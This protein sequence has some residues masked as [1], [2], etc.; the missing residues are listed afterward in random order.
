[1]VLTLMSSV[2]AAQDAKTVIDNA[3]RAMGADRVK[4]L[5]YSGSGADFGLGQGQ[6][7]GPYPRFLNKTHTRVI[8][9]ETPATHMTRVRLQG[10]NPP[11]GGQ[12][13]PMRGE[14]TQNQ[15]V[16]VNP[17]TPWGNQLPI[18]MDPIGFLRAAAARNA[19]VQTQTREGRTYQVVSFTAPNKAMFNGYI[20][21]QNLVERVETWID[22]AMFGDMLVEV[23]YALYRDFDG[24]KYP[25]SIV[26]KRG[27]W[28]TLQLTLADVKFNVAANIK[29]PEGGGGGAQGIPQTTEKLAEGIYL[30]N[31]DRAVLVFDFRDYI[32]V[33]EGPTSEARGLYII[34]EAKRLIPNKPIRYV[35]NTHTHFDHASGL[36]PFVAEG[37]TVITH[38][39]NRAFLERVFTA[40]R[41]LNPDTLSRSGRKPRFETMTTRKVLTDGN[42]V[43]ELHQ[44]QGS[45]HHPGIIFAYLPKQKILFE[46]DGYNANVPANSP[47]PNPVGPYTVNLVENVRRLNL[48]IDRIISIHPPPD[49]RVVTMQEMLRAAGM[50]QD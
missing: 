18:W 29:A 31:G 44:Q 39:A 47:T 7:P 35:V 36:R 41:T 50:E 14:T 24:I 46:G 1:M 37:A 15:T 19:T 10:E 28:P 38:E 49:N 43:I 40:P 32:V 23:D 25:T 11:R 21:A 33:L 5:E 17:K 16:V 26:E 27:G 3:S 2:A 30:L 6:N 42:H 4:T 9:F 45:N 34:E 13:Q 48:D 20:N 22:E 8:D 12:N